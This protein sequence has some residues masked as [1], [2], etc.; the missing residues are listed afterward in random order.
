MNRKLQQTTV[1]KAAR[2]VA[3]WVVCCVL[4]SA[5]VV[6]TGP[7]VSFGQSIA[8]EAPAPAEEHE[9]QHEELAVGSQARS[10]C[11]GAADRPPRLACLR[12]AGHSF[13]CTRLGGTTERG[14][15]LPNGLMAPLLC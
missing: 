7:M 14:H 12:H 3:R 13:G 1:L 2:A 6:G 8:S 15:R 5:S 9:I 4:V 10:M 11:R